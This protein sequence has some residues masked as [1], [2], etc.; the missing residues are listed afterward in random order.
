MSEP[1][2]KHKRNVNYYNRLKQASNQSTKIGY[3]N[4]SPRHKNAGEKNTTYTITDLAII[5]EY[6]N[7]KGNIPPRPFMQLSYTGNK[8]LITKTTAQ[9]YADALMGRLNVP[10]A[11]KR[12]GLLVEGLVKDTLTYGKLTLKPLSKNYKK[13]PS[14]AK[15]TSSSVPLT[16][17]G[18]LKNAVSSKIVKG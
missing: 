5:H 18:T 12:V 4:D 15:V 1:K 9:L 14:G 17:E 8:K 10:T 13:R 11:G 6:G 7:S 16:D 3:F 2:I